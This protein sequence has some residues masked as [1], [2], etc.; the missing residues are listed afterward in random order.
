MCPAK[1]LPPK[2]MKL[3]AIQ[4]DEGPKY[5]LQD[6]LVREW[7]NSFY[8]PRPRRRMLR[9]ISLSKPRWAFH[10]LTAI[11]RLARSLRTARVI[12]FV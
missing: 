5:V 1:K 7:L 9:T 12:L 2:I 11:N 8:P 3:N 10:F 6:E 4:S